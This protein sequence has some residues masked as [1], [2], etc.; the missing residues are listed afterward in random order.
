[1]AETNLIDQLGQF[2]AWKQVRSRLLTQLQPWLKK[3]GLFT[4]EVRN[5]IDHALRALHEE[6]VT[7]AV[8]GEFSRGKTELINALFFANH[9]RRLLPT[10]AGRTTMYPTEILCD[11]ERPPQLSL[12]PIETRREE[13]SLAALRDDIDRWQVFELELDDPESLAERLQIL[14]ES[15]QVSKREAAELGLFQEQEDADSGHVSIPR[16]RLAQLNIRHPLLA[17]GLRILDT[18]GLNAIGSEPELT[19]EMLP[20]AHAVLFVLAADTGVTQSDLEIW[21]KFIQRPNHQERRGAM[22]VLNK[23]DT[24]WDELRSSRHIAE[25]IINQCREVSKTLKVDPQQIFATSAQKALLA[26]IQQDPA[27]EQRSGI[28]GL[29]K[30]L[31]KTVVTNRMRLIQDEH[32]HRVTEAIEALEIIIRGRQERNE[33]QRQSLLDLAG[34]SDSAIERMLAATQGD[35][36]HY[37]ASVDAY[38]QGLAAFRQHGHTLLDA[39][40]IRTLDKTLNDIH[41]M[42]TGAWTTYG[43]KDAMLRLFE[44][45]N[46]RIEVAARQTQSMRR[47]LRNIHRRFQ[48]EHHFKLPPPPMF[49]IVKH[50]VEL[51]LLDQEADI[52]RNS[53]RTALMEQH[54]VTRRYFSTIVKRA[55]RIIQAA[56][57]DAKHWH[58]TAL[59]PLAMEV[60]EYRNTLA[61]QILDLRK[62]GDS[63]Q[64][65]QQRIVALR[66]DNARL[67]AQLTSFGKVHELL[68][69]PQPV[70]VPGAGRR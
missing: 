4:S 32:T 59:L 2:Q 40:N 13:H 17:Q 44:D 69:N 15:K 16:W 46:S 26:R 61:Q 41:E 52:F 43:L 33:H 6:H 37:Q 50:Q 56:H 65:V 12:L 68:A 49:S 3:Q 31:G 18:P 38:Q 10:D 53:A 20:A 64:T 25:S 5:A 66:R 23:T 54:F 36:E 28:A 45:I 51:S 63:R 34:Q 47:L 11:P 67:R 30:H 62:A 39:L 48:N 21:Q 35:Y 70:P 8:A 7:V 27:L 42:M 22:V 1:M 14:T 55:E 29:E 19:Y 9:G 57:T 24:L 58:D 60:K